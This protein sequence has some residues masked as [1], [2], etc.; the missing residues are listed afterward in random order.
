MIAAIEDTIA[1]DRY[2]REREWATT[3]IG[4]LFVRFEIALGLAWATPSQEI[5]SPVAQER[6]DKADKARA[7]FLKALRGW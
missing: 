4:R 5:T 6:R 3:D 1:L 7:E 2:K